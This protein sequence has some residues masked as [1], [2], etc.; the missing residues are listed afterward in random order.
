MQHVASI[1]PREKLKAIHSHIQLLIHSFIQQREDLLCAR[2]CSRCW[3]YSNKQARRGP[4]VKEL[5]N[6]LSR[7]EDV[8]HIITKIFNYQRAKSW[9][10]KTMYWGIWPKQKVRGCSFEEKLFEMDIKDTL[11]SSRWG[12]ERGRGH[13][14]Q[15]EQLVQRLRSRKTERQPGWLELRVRERKLDMS[16]P[17]WCSL[18]RTLSCHKDSGEFLEGFKQR[19]T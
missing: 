11:G 1:C 5:T 12:E 18:V 15:K 14:W 9:S 6:N 4:A 19:R 10:H 3:R 2:H 16:G 7:G 17:W 8:K 13:S